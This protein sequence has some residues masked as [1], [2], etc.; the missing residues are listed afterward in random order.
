MFSPV[1][2]QESRFVDGNRYTVHACF[3]NR[4]SAEKGL[5]ISKVNI[6]SK[7]R[8]DFKT[9]ELVKKR[10]I[11]WQRSIRE[12]ALSHELVEHVNHFIDDWTHPIKNVVVWD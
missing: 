5:G 12:V 6:I 8:F 4:M 11:C 3:S 10:G 7:L 2:D 1:V 9:F